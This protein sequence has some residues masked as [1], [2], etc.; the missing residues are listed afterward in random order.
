MDELHPMRRMRAAVLANLKKNAPTWPGMPPDQW[1][2]LDSETT[3]QALISALEAGGHEATFLEGDRTLLGNLEKLQPDICF[4][5][6]EGH[7]GDGR[8][9]QVP[10]LLEML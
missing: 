2:D 5:I 6:G 4:N 1:D 3:I 8:D 9:A 10:A 7:W